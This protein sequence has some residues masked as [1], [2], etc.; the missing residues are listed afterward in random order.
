MTGLEGARR[1]TFVASPPAAS[2]EHRPCCSRLWLGLKATDQCKA[3]AITD[4][5]SIP[6]AHWL[7]CP[8]CRPS[9]SVT[10]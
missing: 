6:V 2:L 8:C 10:I 7:S 9:D 4:Q 3:S 1:L 5:K